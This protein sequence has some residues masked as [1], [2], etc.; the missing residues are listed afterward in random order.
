M[1]LKMFQNKTFKIV[2][3]YKIYL[4]KTY[5]LRCLFVPAKKKN[6][7]GVPSVT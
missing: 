2:F 3:S 6:S 5:H 1:K 7:K 4:N